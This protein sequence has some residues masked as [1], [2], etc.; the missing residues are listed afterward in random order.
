M[1]S[2]SGSERYIKAIGLSFADE[3]KSREQFL[4]LMRTTSDE[5]RQLNKFARANY[6][7]VVSVQVV[8]QPS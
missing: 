2:T 3:R 1:G 6:G 5:V 8:T 7:I 4:S